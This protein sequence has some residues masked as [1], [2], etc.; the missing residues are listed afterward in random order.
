MIPDILFFNIL[1]F[2]YFWPCWV[3]MAVRDF[4]LVAARG[5]LTAVVSLVAKHG[6]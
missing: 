4:S 6:L 5:L 2:I 3:F 1:L